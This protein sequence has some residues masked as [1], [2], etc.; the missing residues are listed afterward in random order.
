[1]PLV[2]LAIQV[3]PWAAI[4]GLVLLA[5]ADSLFGSLVAIFATGLLIASLLFHEFGHILAASMTNVSVHAIGIS[6]VGTYIQRQRSSS[7]WTESLISLAG[8]LTSLV[9][10]AFFALGHGHVYVWLTEMNLLVAMSNLVPIAGTDGDRA[11]DAICIAT[12][13]KQL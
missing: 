4:S 9:L 3:S 12:M 6:A 2:R 1:M 7:P 11:L 8:P 10:A 13:R 5:W